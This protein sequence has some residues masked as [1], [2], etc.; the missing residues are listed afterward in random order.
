MVIFYLLIAIIPV[1]LSFAAT[2]FQMFVCKKIRA[3]EV[4]PNGSGFDQYQM[5]Q[6][7]SIRV[8]SG[9]SKLIL[10]KYEYYKPG[11]FEYTLERGDGAPVYEYGNRFEY[12]YFADTEYLD[13]RFFTHAPINMSD[14][15]VQ[16]Y[17]EHHFLYD[18]DWYGWATASALFECVKKI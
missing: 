11:K 13:L 3:L 1:Q 14:Q 15:K 2:P 10:D 5:N 16:L 9:K 12:R 17:A 7:F 4:G 6:G 18:A 8:E